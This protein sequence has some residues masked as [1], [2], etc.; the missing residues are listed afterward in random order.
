[1]ETHQKISK[2][3]TCNILER[4]TGIP[5]CRQAGNPNPSYVSG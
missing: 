3:D 1:M 4:E 5:A 2:T